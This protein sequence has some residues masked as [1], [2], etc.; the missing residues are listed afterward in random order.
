MV[1][2]LSPDATQQS[3]LEELLRAQQDPQSAYYHAWLTP[4]DFGEHFGVSLNDLQQVV[5]WLRN[6]GKEVEEIPASRRTIIFSGTA[7]QV[8]SAFHTSL[9]TYRVGGELHYANATDPQIPQAFTGVVHGVLALHD[10][11]SAASHLVVKP[12]FTSGSAHYLSPKDWDIIYDVNPL[13]GLGLDGTGQSIA[14]I[15]RV[16]I[17]TSDVNTFRSNF[18]L[19]ANPPQIIVNGPDPGGS[20]SG[21]ATE[22]SLDVEWAGAIAQNATVKFVTTK[23]AA[24]DG[25][26]LSAQYAVTNKI[27][28]ILTVSY[29]L[30]EAASGQSGNAFWNSLWSQAAAQGMSVFVSSG[31]TGAAGCDGGSEQTAVHGTGVNSICSTPYS[32]CVG[33][34]EFNDNSNP[35]LYWSSSNNSGY[36]SALGYIPEL[37][38]NESAATGGLWASNGGVSIIYSKPSWQSAPGVPADGKRDVPDIAMAAAIHDSYLIEQ[39]GSMYCVGGTSAAAPSLA[40]LMALLIQR[41]RG[42]QGNLNPGLYKLD[43]QQ[44]SAGGTAVFH[45]ITG[46]NNTVPGVTGFNAGTGYDRVTGLGSVDAYLLVDNWT[47]VTSTNFTFTLNASTA[48]VTR[49]S[50]AKVTL[51]LTAQGGFNSPVTLS[52]SGLPSGVTVAFSP[53]TLTAS[54]PVTAT[55]SANSTAAV[56]SSQITLSGTGA[57]ITRT[58]ALSLTVP[59]PSLNLT[60]SASS[61]TVAVG[62]SSSVTLST[63]VLNGFSSA[64]ALSVTGLPNG[65]T[66]VFA[67]TS[68]ASPGSGASKLTL[69]AASSTTTGSSSLTISATGGG[70]TKTQTFSLTVAPAPSFSLSASASSASVAAGASTSITLST[71]GLNAFSSAIAISVT[72]LPKGVTAAFAPASIASPGSGT[73]KLT[74]TSASTASTGNSTLTISATGAGVTKTLT[75]TLTVSPAPSFSLTANSSTATIAKGASTSLTLSATGQNGFTSSVALSLTGFPKGVTAT[76]SPASLSPSS[77]GTAAASKLTLTASSTATTGAS[78]LTVT[79]TGAGVTKTQT[80]TLNVVAPASH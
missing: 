13:F 53:Q 17:L 27:A 46:G 65:V 20:T 10:F 11:Q 45:D 47:A 66:A 22:S 2:V 60:A 78:T 70:V 49:G 51:T 43:T 28:P 32:T 41:A 42:A 62:G 34:T 48:S 16:D 80:I 7:A 74:L 36:A 37:A 23:S 72:G 26:A 77:I 6:H 5:S 75:L 33:G 52:A 64:V 59:Q 4:A 44:L 18:G 76:F 71:S 30:C 54:T 24:S 19:S 15:G 9:Q 79:A 25:I 12:E 68:I 73:S 55:F 67:P 39:Q 8:Q 56:G 1:L 14:V 21:D 31:D 57:G 61:S 50:S 29:G 40:S 35:S 38:W 69:T 63:A 58:A 3:A